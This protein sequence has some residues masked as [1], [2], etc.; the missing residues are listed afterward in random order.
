[1][2]IMIYAA[3]SWGC[4]TALAMAGCPPGSETVLACTAGGGAK[5]L[6]V[7][8]E[9]DAVRYTYGSPGAEPDLRLSEPVA[10][11]AHQPWPGIGR[12]IWEATTFMNAGYAYEAWISTERNEDAVPEG[13]VNVLK[14]EAEVARITCDPGTATIGLWAVD[15]AKQARGICWDMETLKWGSCDQK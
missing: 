1:M 13:G 9:G 5:A 12:A 8:I 10:Q 4:S 3:F 7:C 11:V 2:K 14:G 15:D 6:S